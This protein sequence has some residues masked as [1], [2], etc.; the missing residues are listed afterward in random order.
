MSN[1]H[2]NSI[3]ITKNAEFSISDVGLDSDRNDLSIVLIPTPPEAMPSG[4]VH[5]GGIGSNP[6]TC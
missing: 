5:V 3:L 4:I 6:A 2:D 1:T